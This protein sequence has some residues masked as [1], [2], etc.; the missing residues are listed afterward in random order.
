ML[1]ILNFFRSLFFS[2]NWVLLTCRSFL[3]LLSNPTL[4]LG[5]AVKITKSQLGKHVI[6]YGNTTVLMSKINSYSY[7]GGSSK[8][9]RTTIGKFCSIGENVRIGLGKH[10]LSCQST[11]PG[12]YTNNFDLYGI[13]K[14]Y[15]CPISE[16][17]EIT[18]GN[19]V[20]IGTS[21]IILDGV[22][23]GDGAV[24]A[25]GAVV[26]KDVPPYAIVAGVPAKIIKYRFSEEKILHLL[27]EKWWDKY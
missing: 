15:D 1:N 5:R 24:I 9:S 19:D 10:P 21:A 20:W 25:A 18:I 22:N 11:Y 16:Y 12:F 2:E 8:V 17:E 26:T 6:I 27:K 7:I 14:E 13:K 23:I 3:L 4:K